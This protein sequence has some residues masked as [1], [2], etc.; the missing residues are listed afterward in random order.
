MSCDTFCESG[1]VLSVIL[2]T[3]CLVISYEFFKRLSDTE[4]NWF[5]VQLL[6]KAGY[7]LVNS[8]A[9]KKINDQE[10]PQSNRIFLNQMENRAKATYVI[11]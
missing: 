9:V 10:L 5:P 3:R 8:G 2:V 6:S 4:F 7:G 1:S 11:W